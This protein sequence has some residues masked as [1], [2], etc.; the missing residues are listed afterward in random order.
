MKQTWLIFS[1]PSNCVLGD[2][3]S[4]KDCLLVCARQNRRGPRQTKTSKDT[5]RKLDELPVRFVTR[6]AVLV[7]APGAANNY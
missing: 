4:V 2:L 7:T 5:V 6:G 3:A 1:R